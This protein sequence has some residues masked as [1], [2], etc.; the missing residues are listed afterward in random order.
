MHP[1]DRTDPSRSFQP[2]GMQITDREYSRHYALGI[3]DP[4]SYSTSGQCIIHFQEYRYGAGSEVRHG[5][6]VQDNQ[7]GSGAKQLPAPCAEFGRR[8][9][10]KFS[11][12]WRR[13]ENNRSGTGHRTKLRKCIATSHHP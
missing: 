12:W 13:G 7:H 11:E 6:E 8:S 9:R 3:D 4:Q 10:V 2:S 1:A 5:A